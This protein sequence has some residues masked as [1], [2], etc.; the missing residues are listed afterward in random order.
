M[1]GSAR[2][3][4][5]WKTSD[6]TKSGQQPRRAS[7]GVFNYRF[8]KD[9]AASKA[10]KMHGILTSRAVAK[11]A[12]TEC[13]PFLQGLVTQDILHIEP[14]AGAFTALLTPQGKILFDFFLTPHADGFL[15]DCAAD[16]ID[17]LV[18]RLTLYRLRAKI[19]IEKM[20]GLSVCCFDNGT[21]DDAVATFA[22]PRHPAMPVRQIIPADRDAAS[23]DDE[24]HARRIDLGIPEFGSD[25]AAE[26]MF[27][28]DVNYDALN[29]VS[30]KKGCFVGQE[31]SSRMKRKGEIRKRTLIA[32]FEGAPPAKG[33]P[34]VAGESTIGE[35]LSGCEGAALALI[36]LDRKAN[37]EQ[38]GGSPSSGETELQLAIP[39]YLEQG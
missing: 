19:L 12:G 18:K 34:I 9:Y 33:A 3:I 10:L 36:R 14:G 35:M 16:A 6:C 30:Y 21:A 26:E 25:F 22:D 11:I 15:I 5:L 7:G 37:A 13:R 1:H 28:L 4:L 2:N 38:S 17:A 24:Y 27:L 31:V 32:S 23:I 20:S 39:T 8:S 29:A